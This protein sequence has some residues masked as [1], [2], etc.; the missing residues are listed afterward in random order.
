[1]ITQRRAAEKMG[2][3]DRWV[4]KLLVARGWTRITIRAHV[5]AARDEARMTRRAAAN[6][7]HCV[8]VGRP[9][10]PQPTPPLASRAWITPIPEHNCSRL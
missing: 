10:G 6:E 3:S 2:I 7:N 1:M 5:Y 4:R 8:F 9:P